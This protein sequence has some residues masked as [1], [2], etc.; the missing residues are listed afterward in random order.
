MKLSFV[1]AE[2][3]ANAAEAAA[4]PAQTMTG[5]VGCRAQCIDLC[6]HGLDGF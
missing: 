6:M 5:H 2:Y 1:I 3:P 4:V